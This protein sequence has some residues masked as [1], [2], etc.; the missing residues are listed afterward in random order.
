MNDYNYEGGHWLRVGIRFP[1]VRTMYISLPVPGPT[2]VL[3][4]SHGFRVHSGKWNTTTFQRNFCLE[5]CVP[6]TQSV[7][8][9]VSPLQMISDQWVLTAWYF[10]HSLVAE[11]TSQVWIDSTSTT[12]CDMNLRPLTQPSNSTVRSWRLHSN[13]FRRSGEH[14]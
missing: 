7:A 3:T 11:P 10:C 14:S 2:L 9:L 8:Q 5:F 12:W 1:N 13:G 6:F 4:R